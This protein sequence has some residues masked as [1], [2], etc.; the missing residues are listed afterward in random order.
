MRTIAVDFC[1]LMNLLYVANRVLLLL[2]H[3]G[4]IQGL[5]YIWIT[6]GFKGMFKENDTNCAPI[7]PNSVVKFFYIWL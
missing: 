5:K 2:L 1:G 3:N 4:T 7:V 6:E